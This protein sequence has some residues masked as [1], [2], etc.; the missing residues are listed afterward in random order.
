MVR[1]AVVRTASSLL[2]LNVN[3]FL[4]PLPNALDPQLKTQVSC[5]DDDLNLIYRVMIGLDLESAQLTR[6]FVSRE[7]IPIN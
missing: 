3:V 7:I 5:T 1:D 4:F 2:P 6:R